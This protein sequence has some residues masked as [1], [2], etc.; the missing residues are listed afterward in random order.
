MAPVI[1][2]LTRHPGVIVS[3]VCATAQHRQMLDQVLSLFP[4]VPDYDLNLMRG[5]N[6]QRK[7]LR[8]CS[9]A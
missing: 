8:P 2:E 4:I 5:H 6:P 1:Y 3:R 9:P 7:W